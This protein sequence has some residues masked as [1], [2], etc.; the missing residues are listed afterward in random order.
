VPREPSPLG[1]VTVTRW[2]EQHP[3]WQGKHWSYTDPD[4]DGARRLHP[5]NV[6]PRTKTQH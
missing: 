1:E 5:I 2:R 3:D 4:D 6:G